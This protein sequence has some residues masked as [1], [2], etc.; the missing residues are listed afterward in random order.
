[1]RDG[2]SRGGARG[3]GHVLSA[4]FVDYDNIYLSLKRK[5]E[6]AA[7]RFSK[8]A[9]GW[10]RGLETG[11]LI[12]E[13][14]GML[15]R[16]VRRIVMNRCY[17]NPVPRRNQSDNSTDMHS[18]PFV[19][20][21][22]LRAGFEV[23]DCPPLTA[24]LKNSADIRMVMDMRDYLAHD[25]YFDEFIVL[26]GDADF[27]P[28]LHRLRQH[29]RKTVVFAN[30]VTAQP[31]TAICDGEVR[32][33]DLIA[34]LLEGRVPEIGETPVLA[35]PPPLAATPLQAQ[36][37]P[38]HA[39]P[40]L[41]DLR[42]AIIAEVV[43]GVRA[44]AGPVP[45]EALADRALRTLG[46]ERTVGSRWAGAGSFHELLRYGLPSE[47]LLSEHPPYVAYEQSRHQMAQPAAAEPPVAPMPVMPP[48][49]Y[50]E[51][52]PTG[53]A[54]PEQPLPAI[55]APVAAPRVQPAHAPH[56][57][58]PAQALPAQQAA[59]LQAHLQ[60][61]MSPRVAQPAALATRAQSNEPLLHRA[62]AATSASY[63]PRAEPPPSAQQSIARIQEA[64]Q[65]PPLSPAEYRVLFELMASEIAENGLSGAQTLT[66]IA[67]RAEARGIAA[68][69]EDVRF[70]LEAVSEADPWFEQGASANLFA[71]RFRNFV[72][73]RCREQGLRLSANELDLVDAWFAGGPTPEAA[74]R[75]APPPA[76]AIEPPA[77]VEPAPPP[78]DAGAGS[79]AASGGRAQRWWAMG[80]R[81]LGAERAGGTERTAPAAR[82]AASESDDDMPRFVRTRHR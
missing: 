48:P 53:Y 31:Y 52:A 27:T 68:R 26:S 36:P 22:F 12:T 39:A 20:H 4:I 15:G 76:R 62:P 8:D 69:R 65:A 29:A 55:T 63:A 82:A 45:L 70:L 78:L 67:Q 47:V 9:A 54:P 46:H 64:C 3:E 60:A 6:E 28:L 37:L 18:F 42:A 61:Q 66:A 25:T 79:A 1:M 35:A 49:A 7:K 40:R 30:D 56:G 77:P 23:I 10:L 44:S 16:P 81:V 71:G 59:A 73:V 75:S 50:A 58:A 33:S 2:N 43:Q 24:Q 19:R 57:T 13:T 38:P 17:G 11:Q 14:N 72:V 32:E 74:P 41:E 21:H 5:N 34:L 51:P 80:E